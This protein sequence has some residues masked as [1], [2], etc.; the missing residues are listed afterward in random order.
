MSFGDILERPS[1]ILRMNIDEYI[2]NWHTNE[3]ILF[4]LVMDLPVEKLFLL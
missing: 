3:E 2:R 4:S 1:R